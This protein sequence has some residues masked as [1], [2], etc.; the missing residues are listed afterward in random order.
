MSDGEIHSIP[1]P[2]LYQILF[3]ENPAPSILS[4][5]DIKRKEKRL[6]EAVKIYKAKVAQS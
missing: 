1:F 5:D 6:A 2:L 3:I 4:L